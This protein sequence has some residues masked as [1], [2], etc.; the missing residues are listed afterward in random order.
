MSDLFLITV[1]KSDWF[2][3]Y[4]YTTKYAPIWIDPDSERSMNEGFYK[5]EI[6]QLLDQRLKKE[7][8]FIIGNTD[9]LVEHVDVY[10]PASFQDCEKLSWLIQKQAVDAL[11]SMVGK[12]EQPAILFNRLLRSR[13]RSGLS[14]YLGVSLNDGPRN[15]FFDGPP[16]AK[17][18]KDFLPSYR[19]RLQIM[20]TS[21]VLPQSDPDMDDNDVAREILFVHMAEAMGLD[22]YSHN[23]FIGTVPTEHQLTK[24]LQHALERAS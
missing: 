15:H 8:K 7:P 11:H 20:A 12:L 22:Q 17:T 3:T 13:S 23:R 14:Q 6:E 5:E 1:K 24:E 2:S 16:S 4:R 18:I 9:A 21:G 10:T 19:Q